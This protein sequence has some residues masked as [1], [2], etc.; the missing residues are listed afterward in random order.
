MSGD[1]VIWNLDDS[2][3][4]LFAQDE[5]GV[6][7]YVAGDHD[8]VRERVEIELDDDEDTGRFNDLDAVFDSLIDDDSLT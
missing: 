6:P 7:V 4:V 8:T 3:L 5:D 1:D 2:P